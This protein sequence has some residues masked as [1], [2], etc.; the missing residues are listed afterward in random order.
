[1]LLHRQLQHV[2]PAVLCTCCGNE[3]ASCPSLTLNPLAALSLVTRYACHHQDAS[4]GT[5]LFSGY[6][7]AS[8]SNGVTS[9]AATT[10]DTCVN[11]CALD[12]ECHFSEF[13]YD[14]QSGDYTPGCFLFKPATGSSSDRAVYYKLPPTLDVSAASVQAASVR[15]AGVSAPHTVGSSSSS[16]SS[17]VVKAQSVASG[18]YVKY[19]YASTIFLPFDSANLQT[20]SS[21]SA[22][23][24]ACDMSAACWGF[25]E[26][27][28][29]GYALKAGNDLVGARTVVNA[30][31]ADEASGT[32]SM[33]I[34]QP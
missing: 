34:V 32:A 4:V 15:I 7:S 25:V 28:A 20:A 12:A 5:S 24:A 26:V 33:R 10:L 27:P 23:A 17:G 29:G 19:S 14:D 21:L 18:L 2:G 31:K 6:V 30:M 22:A 13:R 3:F 11:A 1:M 8:T 9:N 16:S